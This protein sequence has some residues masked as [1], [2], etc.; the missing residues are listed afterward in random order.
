LVEAEDGTAD[1]LAELEAE[2]EEEEEE[3]RGRR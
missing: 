3:E 1:V 2:A